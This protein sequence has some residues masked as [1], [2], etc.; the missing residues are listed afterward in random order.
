MAGSHI[1]PLWVNDL[2]AQVGPR[3][4]LGDFPS[5]IPGFHAI[6]AR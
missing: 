2:D 1:N 3:V 5:D 4:A 6:E